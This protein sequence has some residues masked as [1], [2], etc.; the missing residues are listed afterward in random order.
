MKQYNNIEESDGPEM[1]YHVSKNGNDQFTGTV[2][3]P[4]CT[5]SRAASAAVA[6]DSII[7]HAGIYREWV[8]PKNGGTK[9]HR[10]IYQSAGDG[11]VVITGA[12]SVSDWKNEGGRVWSAEI[13][14]SLFTV[15]NPFREELSGDW[16][17]PGAFVPHLGEVFLNGK[18][19]YE[20]ESLEKV[21]KPTIWPEAKYPQDSLRVWYA[22]VDERVTKIWADFGDVDPRRE[23]V[24]ISARPYCFWP[25]KEGIGYIT[26]KGFTLC[27]A[28]PQWAPPTALQEGLIGPHWSKGWVIENNII[29]ESKCVGVSLGKAAGSGDNERP[30]QR[31]KG[32]TQREQEVIFR[33]LRENWN[34]EQIGGHI[35]Q[36]NVIHDCE[37]AG[38]AGHMGG[39]FSRI[40]KNRIYNIHHKRI[41]HGAEVGG[42]KLHASLDTQI[43]DNSIYSCYRALWL[44]W[45]AQGTRI[46]RNI[47]FDNLSEDLFVE[48]CHGP[49]L[50][51]HNLFLSKMNFRNMAQGGAF[52]HNLFAGSIL[53]RA[54]LTRWTPYHFPHETAVAG[55]SN[56]VGGDDRFYNNLFIGNQDSDRK[57]RQMTFFEH[58]PLDRKKEEGGREQAMD[59]VPDD[60]VCYLHP[61]GLGAYDL[62]PCEIEKQ[63]WEF[64][65][66]ERKERTEK[67]GAVYPLGRWALP[68]WAGGN[69]YFGDAVPGVH[70]ADAKTFHEKGIEV[71]TDTQTGRVQVRIVNPELLREASVEIMSGERLEKTYQAEM[72]YENPDGTPVCFDTDFYGK[73]RTCV[74]TVP[75]PFEL[76]DKERK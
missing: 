55:Y 62:Y 6:G 71:L 65:E 76:T 73:K 56:I 75:G 8:N 50:A 14:N 49:Y 22:Q 39:A 32:G 7:V 72:A 61:P 17:F 68:V 34:K 42:I 16:L 37:Q 53:Q 54:E 36:N 38:I 67:Y 46:S 15:R 64:S 58:L 48:V 33:A 5:I 31:F 52:V 3:Q 66:E 60:S 70:E 74:R 21:R 20:V 12:E 19:F 47:F 27:Q 40:S 44:D 4:F 11:E 35:V 13:D 63:E 28:A 51:D 41:F 24:E 69:A 18:S 23:N 2:E 10:I 43:S 9:E 25:A 1:E 45:Q 29:R 26:V 57:V 30:M 59:G